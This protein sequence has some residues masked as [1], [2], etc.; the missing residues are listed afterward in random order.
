MNTD[1]IYACLLYTSL[2]SQGTMN[3]MITCAEHFSV[4]ECLEKIQAYRVQDTVEAVTRREAQVY[5]AL[6][7]Q[8]LRVA[9]YDFGVKMCIRDR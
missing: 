3:G 9:L 8:K 7:G 5:P 4:P 1:K 6:G 2:R